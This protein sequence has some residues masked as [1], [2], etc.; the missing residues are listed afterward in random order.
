MQKDKYKGGEGSEQA[1]LL[2]SIFTEARK[3]FDALV[4]VAGDEDINVVLFEHILHLLTVVRSLVQAAVGR[5]KVRTQKRVVGVDDDPRHF[6]A[7]GLSPLQVL[8]HELK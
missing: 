3:R 6:V 7:V 2:K 4:V 5:E 8:Q 1:T